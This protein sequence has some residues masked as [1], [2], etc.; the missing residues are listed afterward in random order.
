M[1]RPNV[2]L[3]FVSLKC[4]NRLEFVTQRLHISFFLYSVVCLFAFVFVCASFYLLNTKWIAAATKKA[5]PLVSLFFLLS[6]L[7][8]CLFDIGMFLFFQK[9]NILLRLS[10]NFWLIYFLLGLQKRKKERW[11]IGLNLHPVCR[12]KKGL[13][14]SHTTLKGAS[15]H[16][17]LDDDGD[18]LVVFLLL[19]FS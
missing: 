2:L 7:E 15:S 14:R 10:H 17:S 13:N 3:S 11:S 18:T 9:L 6:I 5:H 12:K 1:I 4:F 8:T 16:L 19:L